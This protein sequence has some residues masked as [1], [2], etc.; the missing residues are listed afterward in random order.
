MD[1]NPRFAHDKLRE[2]LL[3]GLDEDERLRLHRQVAE[4]VET[5]YP[6]DRRYAAALAHHWDGAG[7]SAQAMYYLGV[8]AHQALMASAYTEAIELFERVLDLLPGQ[9]TPNTLGQRALVSQRIAS[10]YWG[11]GQY[12]LSEKLYADS[13]RWFREVDDRMGMA[14]ALKGLGDVTRRRGDYADAKSYFL[15]SLALCQ[16]NGDPMS[17]AQALARVG[18][19]ARNQGDVVEAESYY[20]QSLTIFQD[21]GLQQHTGS[22]MSGLGLVA[23]DQGNYALARQYMRASLEITRGLHNPTG[24]AL[25]LT[26][27]A[28]IEYLDGAYVEARTHSL[29][30]LRL[31]E[32]V[33]DRWMIGNNLGNLGKIVLALG[34]ED[35][36]LDYLRQGLAVSMTIGAT[37]LTLEILPGVAKLWMRRGHHKRALSLLH[38]A[39]THPATYYEVKQQAEPLLAQIRQVLSSEQIDAVVQTPLALESVLDEIIYGDI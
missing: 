7:D 20:Q 32:A 1:A 18:L 36:A 30:S 33:G 39:V 23:A 22:L 31:S 8:A 37:P 16:E 26:G 38:L 3:A 25:V 13:L 5:V 34:D 29:E 15:E 24:T 27:L 28:W 9:Q 12:D 14:D 35:D 21:A 6:G 2:V 10:A 19:V 17:L 4:A 11:L